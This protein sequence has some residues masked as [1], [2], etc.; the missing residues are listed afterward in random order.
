MQMRDELDQSIGFSRVIDVISKSKKPVV[1]H[2]AL[3]DFVYVFNQFY[4]PLPPTLAEFKRELTELFPVIYDTKHVALRSPLIEKLP[5]TGL[6]SLFEYM[7]DNVTPTPD[8]LL[9]SDARFDGY[10]AALKAEGDSDEKLLCHEAGFDAFMTGVCFL[11]LL[12][13]DANGELPESSSIGSSVR[14]TERLQELETYKNQLNLMIS[15]EKFLDL[16]NPS[17]TIDRSRVYR[18]SSSKRK[19]HQLRMEDVF[20]STKVQRVVREGDQGAFVVLADA[21]YTLSA[22]AP[23]DL[24]ITPYSEYVSAQEQK[25]KDE[26]SAADQK[27]YERLHAEFAPSEAAEKPAAAAT[28]AFPALAATPEAAASSWT[29][30]TIS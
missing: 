4:K 9:S 11:G 12:A 19:L 25:A 20:E 8:A 7:R 17:Q 3:L 6:S 15:D 18:V 26:Q 28:G 24:T 23:E 30:C 14:L 1:G 21:A 27:L 2:N 16:G 13:H 10:R 22:D 5:S 29:R